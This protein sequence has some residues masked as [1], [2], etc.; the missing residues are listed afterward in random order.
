MT[1]SGKLVGAAVGLLVGLVFVLAGWR[2]ALILLGFSLAG[3]LVGVWLD[4]REDIKRRV[5]AFIERASGG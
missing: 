3:L 4:S 5:R 1:V 2:I